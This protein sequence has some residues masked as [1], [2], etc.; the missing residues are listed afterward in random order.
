[1]IVTWPPSMETTQALVRCA[2]AAGFHFGKDTAIVAVQHMLWQ[3]T[4]LFRAIGDLGVERQNIFALGKVFSNAP[5]VIGT[6]RQSGVTVADSSKPPPGYF[7][8]YFKRDV[9]RFWKI[10][11]SLLS[12]RDIKRIIVL[13][14]GGECIKNTPPELMRRYPMTGVEQTSQGIAVFEERPPPYALV[15]WA[16]TAVKLHIGGPI[17]S[18]YLIANVGERFLKG[19]LL[20]NKQAGIMGLGSMGV[21]VT[22]LLLRDGN[23][24]FFFDRDAHVR[25]PQDLSDRI[26]RYHSLE[27]LM[28]TCE[29][30]F[31]CTGRDP[32]R[33]KWPMNYRRG[34]KLISGSSGDQEFGPIIRDLKQYPSF[35]VDP[36]TLD[37]TCDGPC[38]P[39]FI[40]YHGYPYNFIIRNGE[41]VPT[42][43]VQLETGGLLAGL[44]QARIHFA[45]SEEGV[46]KNAS[47]QRVSPEAQ[48]FVFETW[49]RVMKKDNINFKE[50]FGYD[51]ATLSAARHEQWYIDNSEPNPAAGYTPGSSVEDAMKRIV[52]SNS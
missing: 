52:N 25:I 22:R 23:K 16:R 9:R 43:I 11:Q 42:R 17:F 1:M 24:V 41:A 26:T 39:I 51:E 4:D 28:T 21:A 38:G 50:R 35:K 15:S 47:F 13:D 19:Q 3:T 2:K 44:I 48:R 27:Q 46:E 36:V 40:P 6:L 30:V 31:G 34:I 45:L 8:D 10:I 5:E 12:R 18:H 14:D 7:D 32:F 37:I 49:T 29:Y 20:H 33:D